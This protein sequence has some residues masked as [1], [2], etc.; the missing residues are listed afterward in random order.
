MDCMGQ[1]QGTRVSS[2]GRGRIRNRGGNVWGKSKKL[3]KQWLKG[4]GTGVAIVG[5]R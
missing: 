3:G 1:G 4:A 2:N 5:C